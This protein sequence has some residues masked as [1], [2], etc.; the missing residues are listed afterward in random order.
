[1]LFRGIKFPYAI[2]ASGATGNFGENYWYSRFEEK[3]GILN[4]KGLGFVS[5]TATLNARRGNT[6]FIYDEKYYPPA[7]IKPKSIK[8]D[9]IRKNVVNAVG[10]GNPGLKAFLN[11]NNWQNITTPFWISIMSIAENKKERK[12]EME[13]MV[14]LL[15]KE[16]PNFKAP[17]GLQINLSCPNTGH[18]TCGLATEANDMIN[19]AA[20]L[21]VPIMAKFSI[22]TSTINNL[23]ELEENQ[24][25]DALC[26][27]NTIPYNWKP[28]ENFY[29]KELS[30]SWKKPFGETSPLKKMGSGGISGE[31]I[32]P[33]VLHF[34]RELRKAGFKK[35]INGGGGIMEANDVN[36]YK[37]VGADSIFFGSVIMVRP[38]N[39]QKIIKRA[40]QIFT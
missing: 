33:F 29:G 16:K 31:T 11:T 17:F 3:L 38:W 35:H 40:N 20:K 18:D 12:K 25:L 15:M 7:E 30:K 27:S 26:L 8:I 6:S 19:I 4:K 32:K 5:K 37:N 10:L 21:E 34:I 22:A 14:Q 2:A 39:V 28:D 23:L 13:T 24:N 9:L 1:M 36:L